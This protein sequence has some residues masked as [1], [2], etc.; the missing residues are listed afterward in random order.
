M[1]S[2]STALVPGRFSRILPGMLQ[3]HLKAHSVEAIETALAQALQALI[4]KEVQVNIT[5]LRLDS[6]LGSEADVQMKL[7]F[8]FDDPFG[9][10]E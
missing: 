6:G 4:G 7:F 1:C 5:G 8:P 10:E 9:T 2:D 3:N